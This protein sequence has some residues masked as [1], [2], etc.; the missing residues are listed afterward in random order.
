MNSPPPSL[1]L[2]LTQVSLRYH[3]HLFRTW[4]E[5]GQRVRLQM[6][7]SD[8]ATHSHQTLSLLSFLHKETSKE[9][10]V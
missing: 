9:T 10:M 7:R 5:T 4:R 8:Q 6:P 1:S 2:S 3:L